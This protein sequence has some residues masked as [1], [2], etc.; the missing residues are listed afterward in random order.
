MKTIREIL[1]SHFE[2]NSSLEEIEADI[3]K[4]DEFMALVNNR[5]KVLEDIMMIEDLLKVGSERNF[6][7]TAWENLL[8]QKN[9]ELK[10]LLER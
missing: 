8:V 4:H 5:L 3:F 6:D 1:K 10:K 2:Q 9:N 7:G